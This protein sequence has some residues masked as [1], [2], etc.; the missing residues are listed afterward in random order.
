MLGQK[1]DVSKFEATATV[2]GREVDV[3]IHVAKVE[4]GDDVVVAMGVY[5]SITD[6]EDDV[7]RLIEGVRHDS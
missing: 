3:T 2:A 5:P 6:M 7:F 1:T 4:H